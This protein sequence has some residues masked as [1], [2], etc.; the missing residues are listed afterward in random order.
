MPIERPVLRT[1]MVRRLHDVVAATLEQEL[2]ETNELAL[3]TP[4]VIGWINE[5]REKIDLAIREGDEALFD[6]C[7]NAWAKA[8]D[9]VNELVAE[10][11][12]KAHPDPASWEL[13]YFRWMRVRCIAFD[14]PKYGA[15]AVVPRLP[16]L[17]PPYKSWFTSDEMTA[18]VS[19]K[20][21]QAVIEMA[22]VLPVRPDSL[23][24][25]EKETNVMC[26]DLTGDAMRVTVQRWSRPRYG[27]K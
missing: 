7:L 27:R 11:Y 9:R 20:S 21:I 8:W 15:F 3:Q 22:G 25:A 13:R 19:Y 1:R 26:V 10:A 17:P 18:M 12:R 4:K 2:P 24:P 23:P 16:C 14:S 6:R 5:Q